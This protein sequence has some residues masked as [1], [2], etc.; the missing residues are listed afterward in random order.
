MICNPKFRWI[1][2]LATTVLL[3]TVAV[4]WAV[5]REPQGPMVV[6]HS[7]D[8]GISFSH[9]RGWT[10]REFA[11]WRNPESRDLWHAQLDVLPPHGAQSADSF[12]VNIWAAQPEN[13]A[14]WL[15]ENASVQPSDVDLSEVE[16]S[17]GGHPAYAYE[18]SEGKGESRVAAQMIFFQ[19]ERYVYQIAVNT[20]P[21]Y[22]AQSLAIARSI[23]VDSANTTFDLDP[24]LPELSR[25]AASASGPSVITARGSTCV[26]CASETDSYTNTYECC[27]PKGNCTWKTEQVRSGSDNFKFG[28]TGT[29]RDAYRWMDLQ[30]SK[31]SRSYAQGGTIPAVGAVVVLIKGYLS[32]SVGHVATVTSI[33]STGS[34]SVTEQLCGSRCGQSTTIAT[35]TLRTY[36]GGYIYNSSSP[37]SPSTRSLATTV[38]STTV[39]DD[40]TFTNI[41]NF[42]TVGPGTKETFNGGN[43]AWFTSGGSTT[44]NNWMHATRTST[45]QINMGYW[46][47]GVGASG[48]YELQAYIPNNT[49]ATATAA[50]YRVDL[51]L[52]SPINQGT[53]KG[54]VKIVNPGRSD[55]NWSLS[56]GTRS[57]QLFDTQGGTSGKWLAF[58]AL[59]FIRRS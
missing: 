35:S 19:S 58:D 46:K 32:S 17:V 5:G 43:M 18:T 13:L 10:V 22:A 30:F 24:V 7:E 40:Y 33:G 1:L 42:T 48:V 3:A 51:V 56:S 57:V 8:Y 59:K 23:E 25:S 4:T 39:V 9:P 52:S 29:G 36:L 2:L 31:P 53:T 50:R 20:T 34:I 55:G 47:V 41:Y 27:A 26:G 45:S 49:F 6:Y 38:G 15:Y 11:A 37:P 16:N 54:W 21:P 12:V 44:Y 14:A 28:G